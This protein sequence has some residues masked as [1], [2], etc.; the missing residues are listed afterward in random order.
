MQIFVMFSL[1]R[2]GTRSRVPGVWYPGSGTRGLVPGVCYPESA[3]RGLVH[4]IEVKVGGN[5][6]YEVKLRIFDLHF[7]VPQFAGV[8][9]LWL[10]LSHY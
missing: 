4:A 5:V 8:M 3:T 10:M 9:P 1:E 7:D 2:V 6:G